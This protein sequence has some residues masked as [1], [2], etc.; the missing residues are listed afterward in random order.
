MELGSREVALRGVDQFRMDCQ[1]IEVPGLVRKFL[2]PGKLTVAVVG[3][4]L[5]FGE[6][7]LRRGEV[8]PKGVLRGP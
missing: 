4:F 8:Q 5:R 7:L 2:D 1:P 6:I 3:V